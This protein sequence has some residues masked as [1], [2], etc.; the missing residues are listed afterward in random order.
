[1]DIKKLCTVVDGFYKYA[2][3]ANARQPQN[4]EQ[5]KAKEAQSS[6]MSAA[7]D[8]LQSANQNNPL[9]KYLQEYSLK[10]TDS[11]N[12]KVG[13]KYT[14][15]HSFGG[16]PTHNLEILWTMPENFA[17]VAESLKPGI[18]NIFST[19]VSGL[20]NKNRVNPVNGY[21]V[22]IPIEIRPEIIR[23]QPSPPED[24]DGSVMVNI[25]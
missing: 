24:L 23:K 3:S 12:F 19:T 15:Q 1:M 13:F 20:V 9:L 2:Q 8:I 4:D 25:T 16:K 14:Y 22:I 18:L 7:Y 5:I 6:V 10:S 17:K 11:F 21:D